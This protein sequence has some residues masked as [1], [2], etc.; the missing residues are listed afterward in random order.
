[1]VHSRFY[2]SVFQELAA[3]NMHG[4]INM[5]VGMLDTVDQQ[6]DQFGSACDE[7]RA[8]RLGSM[9]REDPLFAASPASPGSDSAMLQLISL[10]E[11]AADVSPTGRRLFSATSEI[12]LSRALRERQLEAGRRIARE[13]QRGRKI[14]VLGGGILDSA[15]MLIGRDL[16]NVTVVDDDRCTGAR[17]R[18]QFG[19]SLHLIESSPTQFLQATAGAD[20]FEVICSTELADSCASHRLA[21]LM[22]AMRRRLVPGGRIELAALSDQHPGCGW[23]RAYLDWEPCCHRPESLRAMAASAGLAA[24]VYHDETECVVWCEMGAGDAP[25]SSGTHQ[26]R[27]NGGSHD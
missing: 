4:G 6:P 22:P 10:G 2:N 14:C 21:A 11:I 19:G 24:R 8:H 5:L 15:R 16:S 3:G 18:D 9:L 25:E 27:A 12:K 17:L 20:L 13:W 23:R 1:M 26:N 7:L